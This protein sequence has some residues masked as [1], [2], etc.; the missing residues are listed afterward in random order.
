MTMKFPS[1][2][3]LNFV[4]T[5]ILSFQT[6]AYA[7]DSN[8]TTIEK[9]RNGIPLVIRETPGSEIVTL[10]VTFMRG[11]A[12]ESFNRRAVNQLTL[13]TMTYATKT[14]SKQ[15]IFALTE[16]YSIGI[17]CT[18]GVE[19]SQCSALTL[20]EYL[21]QAVDLLAAIVTEP[22]FN[23][24]DISLAKQRR[25]ADF[26]QDL[27]NPESQV[28][29]VVNGIFYDQQHPYRLL[30]QDGIQ[31]TQGL[32]A[33]DLKEYHSN[34]LD[35]SS[36]FM[37]YAGP[38]LPN[39]IRAT[40]QRKFS[41][42]SKRDRPKKIVVAPA[43]DPSKRL[44]FEHRE[45][46]TA[47]IKLKFNAPSITA[48]DAPAAD[49]MFEILSERL[50]EEIRTKRSLS[51]AVYAGT[52]QYNQGIGIISVSTSKPKE[53]I[54][55]IASV[56]KDFK[57]K[58][59]TAEELNEQRNVFTTSYFQTLESQNSLAGALSSFQNYFGNARKLYELPSQLAGVTPADVSR[60]AKEWLKNFRVGVVYD[61]AKFDSKWLK[62]L[63]S[64]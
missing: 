57:A 63:E 31:Q 37:T 9:L 61:K 1:I 33:S 32:K 4:M 2:L 53:T 46:P 21:P 14:F 6:I 27:Q 40:L 52:I 19:V 24:D 7:Q 35:A 42:I 41:K 36:M 17:N 60:I 64:L 20:K 22:S 54:D 59:V 26:Q 51:Y 48:K 29:A 12:D 16:K 8:L 58:G 13:D 23:P 18:G 10:S 15:K 47:Y 3:N 39:N 28:N 43:F 55:A 56:V 38:K 49:L 45:I 50:Q 11:S 34:L 5:L 44:A 62:Q 30:P 25:I